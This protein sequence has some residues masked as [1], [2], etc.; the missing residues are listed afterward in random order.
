MYIL[1]ASF[2]LMRNVSDWSEGQR[3][4]ICLNSLEHI[5]QLNVTGI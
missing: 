1:T 4:A 3:S 5:V 2:N